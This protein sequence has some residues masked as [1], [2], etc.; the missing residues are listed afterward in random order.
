[1]FWV[2]SSI[3]DE[4][5]FILSIVLAQVHLWTERELSL[6][7][8]VMVSSAILVTGANRQLLT[9]QFFKVFSQ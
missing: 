6:F 1:M 2:A 8:R 4:T 7:G 5:N 9:I 3:F